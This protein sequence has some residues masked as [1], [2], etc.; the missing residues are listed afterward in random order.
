[1]NLVPANSAAK[2]IPHPPLSS[3]VALDAP[4]AHSLNDNHPLQQRLA[5]WDDNQKGLQ[6]EMLRRVYGAAEPI[7]RAMEQTIIEKSTFVPESVGGSSNL[8]LNILAN[9][10][11][12]I[13]WEDV[14][15]DHKETSFHQELESR[16]FK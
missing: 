2:Q 16:M 9:R 6:M 5:D 7:R 3:G 12:T 10:D 14:Y 8:H 11:A 13:G 1:M 15:P 4:V